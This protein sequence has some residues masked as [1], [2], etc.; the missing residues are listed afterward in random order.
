MRGFLPVQPHLRL[1]TFNTL[2]RCAKCRER[3]T[4]GERESGKG[5][6]KEKTRSPCFASFT[7]PQKMQRCTPRADSADTRPAGNGD[8]RVGA[9]R[10]VQTLAGVGGSSL[11]KA[12]REAGGVGT[13]GSKG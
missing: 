6:S 13:G 3:K 5:R 7:T 9:Q 10:R 4:K 2:A 1:C 8:V 12:L 11:Q